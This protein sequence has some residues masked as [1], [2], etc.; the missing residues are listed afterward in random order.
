MPRAS[1]QSE[2]E[3]QCNTDKHVP[4]ASPERERERASVIQIKMRATSRRERERERE[5]EIEPVRARFIFTLSDVY[6]LSK[7]KPSNA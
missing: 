4:R 5:R 2:L 6:Y 3:S 1:P 7:L